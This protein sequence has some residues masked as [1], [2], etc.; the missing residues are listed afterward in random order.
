MKIDHRAFKGELY[1]GFA[2]VGQ[3]LASPWRLEMLELLAQRPR[4]VEDLALEL[5]LTV[6]NASKHLRILA[7]SRLVTVRRAGTFAHY[8]IG[9]P[10][11]VRLLRL[12]G[13]V[14]EERLPEITDT[15]NRHVGPRELQALGPSEVARRLQRGAALLDVRPEAEFRAGHLVG[16]RH[17]PLEKLCR[18][19]GTATLSSDRDIIVY[20]RG[21]Y[22]V[23]ADEAVAFLRK[24]GFTAFRL[25]G[26][27][28]DWSLLGEALETSA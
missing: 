20:C 25:S 8:R 26:G 28:A 4:S 10:S 22:C 14:A 11:V 13:A 16:A 18:K 9:S 19:S 3:A 7:A 21:P 12:I 5:G 17:V 2:R 6:A 15:L 27:P 24:R 1:D 23:W